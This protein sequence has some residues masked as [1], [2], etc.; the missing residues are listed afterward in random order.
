METIIWTIFIVCL[1]I[2]GIGCIAY[3]TDDNKSGGG[4]TTGI[5]LILF[6]GANFA[7]ILQELEVKAIDVYRGKTRLVIK[8]RVVDGIIVSKDSTVVF[9]DNIN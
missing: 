3:N 7:A 1:L 9:K 6:C 4:V 2:V 8:E 5:L